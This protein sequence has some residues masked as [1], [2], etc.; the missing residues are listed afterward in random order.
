[1]LRCRTRDTGLTVNLQGSF[2]PEYGFCE[3][4]RMKSLQMRLF[5]FYVSQVKHLETLFTNRSIANVTYVANVPA[6]LLSSFFIFCR[7]PLPPPP[8]PGVL[9]RVR[10]APSA[11]VVFREFPASEIN[12]TGSRG[13]SQSVSGLI[14]LIDQDP[15]L[16]TR[17]RWGR[18]S[19]LGPG[20]VWF[21]N[22]GSKEGRGCLLMA[23]LLPLR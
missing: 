6:C 1:M 16:W 5:I 14:F 3:A 20:N 23:F 8:W 13:R 9:A 22:L 17:P 2:T 11:C 7:S 12:H 19:K 18:L 21:L 10:C 15:K 4:P